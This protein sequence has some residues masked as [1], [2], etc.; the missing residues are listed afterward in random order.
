MKTTVFVCAAQC[1]KLA[2]IV[3]AYPSL[4]G[5]MT[6]ETSSLQLL[7]A[8]QIAQKLC[9]WSWTSLR[10]SCHRLIDHISRVPAVE[11]F[12][13]FRTFVNLVDISI[14]CNRVAVLEPRLSELQLPCSLKR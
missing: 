10:V 8:V 9:H 4:L 7:I 14:S 11:R 1:L 13:L 3:G 2:A 5:K 6:D 12:E